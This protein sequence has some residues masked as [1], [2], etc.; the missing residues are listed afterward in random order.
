[1]KQPSSLLEKLSAFAKKAKDL[2]SQDYSLQDLKRWGSYCSPSSMKRSWKQVLAALKSNPSSLGASKQNLNGDVD[3]S[4]NIK[5]L[6]QIFSA[7]L[8]RNRRASIALLVLALLLIL[9]AF[10]LAPFSQKIQ[11]QLDMRPA[12]WSQL[13]GLI[14]LAKVPAGN[15]GNLGNLGNV[16]GSTS[17]TALDDLELQRIRAA[18]TSRG[19]KPNV[20]RLSADNPPR[21]EFQASDVMF[22]TLLDSLDE[23]RLMWRL[24]P[25]QLNVISTGGPGSVNVSGVLIQYGPQFGGAR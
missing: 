4:F 1:M 12:Q 15:L 3:R 18:M 11:D 8:V 14:K 22:S 24:Y 5:E 17:V 7:L 9:H 19:L 13:Q 6:P 25:E 23:M 21:I 20:L 10:V 16:G 2:V